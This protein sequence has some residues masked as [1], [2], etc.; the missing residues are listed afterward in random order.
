MRA[1]MPLQSPDCRLAQG[2]PGPLQ[3]VFMISGQ[4]LLRPGLSGSGAVQESM[5]RVEKPYTAGIKRIV[6]SSGYKFV[7]LYGV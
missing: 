5:F 3:R 4:S 1:K 6:S 2:E 7:S